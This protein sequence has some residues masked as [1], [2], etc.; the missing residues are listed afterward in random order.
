MEA[1]LLRILWILMLLAGIAGFIFI[2]ILLL[3][4]IYDFVIE[5][6]DDIL[7]DFRR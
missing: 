7:D 3:K 6:I 4:F 5:F 1:M 2:I